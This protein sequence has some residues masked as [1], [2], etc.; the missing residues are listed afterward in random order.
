VVISHH[1]IGDKTMGRGIGDLGKRLLG[2]AEAAGFVGITIPQAVEAELAPMSADKRK[3]VRHDL[4][5][6]IAR[7]MKA[8]VERSRLRVTFSQILGVPTYFY[9]QQNALCPPTQPPESLMQELAALETKALTYLDENRDVP[10]ENNP[11]MGCITP[12]IVLAPTVTVPPA[13]EVAPV[14]NNLTTMPRL[15][16]LRTHDSSGQPLAPRG[17][18]EIMELLKWETEEQTQRRIANDKQRAR[19]RQT[20]TVNQQN[21]IVPPKPQATW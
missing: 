13:P 10:P 14:V 5:W 7:T 9:S 20:G 18:D 16:D 2:R 15:D 17:V 8:L 12:E 3:Q 6:D 21:F 4:S 11:P 1:S 19:L